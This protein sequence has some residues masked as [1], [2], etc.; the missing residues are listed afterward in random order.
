M[1]LRELYNLIGN[2]TIPMDAQ[3]ELV[4]GELRVVAP[5]VA[6]PPRPDDLPPAEAGGTTRTSKGLFRK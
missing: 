1:T 2:S 3:V 4:D 5:A 6:L